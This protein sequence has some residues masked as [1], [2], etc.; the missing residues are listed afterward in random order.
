[1]VTRERQPE[2]HGLGEDSVAPPDHRGLGV[3]ACSRRE[4]LEERG[5][6]LD[7][8][9]GGVAQQDR[10]RGVEDVARR[11]AAME[12]ACVVADELLDVREERDH[13][14]LGGALDLLDARRVEHERLR[15][16]AVRGALGDDAG[17]FHGVAR[18]ELDLEPHLVATL[19]RPQGGEL[20]RR[21]ARDH[22]DRVLSIR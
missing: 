5:R 18:G 10:E 6:A 1:M 2:R 11:H 21:V 13:V 14:V 19:G 22:G 15:A 20:G 17:V 3:L 12:P 7:E 9:V 4:R 16:N 8:A